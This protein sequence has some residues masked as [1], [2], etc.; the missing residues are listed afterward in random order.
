M[1]VCIGENLGSVRKGEDL[2]IDTYY[3]V[4]EPRDDV[5]GIMLAYIHETG[6]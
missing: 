6:D 3:D 2:A 1:S 5:M 4:P